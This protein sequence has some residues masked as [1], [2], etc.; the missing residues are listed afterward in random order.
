L[1]PFGF[2]LIARYRSIER[3]AEAAVAEQLEALSAEI[4]RS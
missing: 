4:A 1:T 3:E 2:S